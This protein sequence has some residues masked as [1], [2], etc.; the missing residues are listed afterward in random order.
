MGGYNFL[1]WKLVGVEGLAVILLLP[2]SLYLLELSNID[3]KKKEQKPHKLVSWVASQQI[4]YLGVIAGGYFLFLGLSG[5]GTTYTIFGI[6]LLL[7]A[8]IL[9]LI[10]LIFIG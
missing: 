10:S 9:L 1:A 5:A 3:P 2:I 8:I 4:C 6:I 7:P